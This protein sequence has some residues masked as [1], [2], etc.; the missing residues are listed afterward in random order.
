M[1]TMAFSRDLAFYAAVILKNILYMTL[2]QDGE[3]ILALF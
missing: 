1:N 2:I 3:I